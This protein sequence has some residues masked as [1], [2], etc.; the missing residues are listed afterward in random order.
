[1]GYTVECAV[2]IL[3]TIEDEMEEI[4]VDIII[5]HDRQNAWGAANIHLY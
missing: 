3:E 2:M 5:L 1:M 4:D